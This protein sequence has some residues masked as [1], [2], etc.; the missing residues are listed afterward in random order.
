MW[1]KYCPISQSSNGCVTWSDS[2]I[3]YLAPEILIAG[4]PHVVD[5]TEYI[6]PDL[7]IVTS[8]GEILH[9]WETAENLYN[10]MMI[11]PILN[12]I[13]TGEFSQEELW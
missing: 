3:G 2:H 12:S 7:M 5:V 4:V 11:H 9:E 1:I 6:A 10:I 13:I 8:M